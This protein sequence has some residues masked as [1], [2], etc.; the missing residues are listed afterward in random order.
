MSGTHCTACGLSF[1][2]HPGTSNLCAQ[3]LSANQT[4]KT[5]ASIIRQ[6]EEAAKRDRHRRI[7]AEKELRS[8]TNQLTR[9]K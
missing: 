7:C 8:L 6:H 1:K 4:I 5:L 9:G 2:S 3:V